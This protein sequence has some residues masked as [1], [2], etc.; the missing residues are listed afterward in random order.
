MSVKKI[1]DKI[2][3]FITNKTI[4]FAFIISVLIHLVVFVAIGK[5]VLYDKTLNNNSVITNVIINLTPL[6]PSSQANEIER[7]HKRHNHNDKIQKNIKNRTK[8]EQVRKNVSNDE[9]STGDIGIPSREILKKINNLENVSINRV[10]KSAK[11]KNNRK[12]DTGNSFDK[13]VNNKIVYPDYSFNEKPIYP[14]I[15]RIKGYE[16]T[17]YL[18]ILVDKYGYVRKVDLKKSSGYNILDRSAIKAAEG[19][20]F[21]PAMKD[22]KPVS[23]TIIVPVIF[24]LNRS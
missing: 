14:R 11:E 16:G 7:R 23:M 6:N 13:E 8:K 4:A 24:K 15:A 19:W 12:K 10:G 22:G 1:R 3:A 20:K 9:G 5:I 21:K 18:K 17:V 2:S